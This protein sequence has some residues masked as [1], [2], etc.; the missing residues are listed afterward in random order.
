MKIKTLAITALLVAGVA[1]TGQSAKAALTYTPGDLFLGFR[2]LG[3]TGATQDYVVNI[4]QF[5]LYTSGNSF[6]IGNVG[7]DLTAVFGASWNT[8]RG[9]GNGVLWSAIGTPYNSSS[10]P[11]TVF[12]SKPQ[13]SVTEFLGKAPGASTQTITNIQDVASGYLFSSANA[14]NAAGT[15][16]NVS[17]GNSWDS[18]FHFVTNLDF[19][20]FDEIEGDFSAGVGSSGAVLDLFQIDPVNGSTATLL[21]SLSISSSGVVTF[22]AVPEPST[23][24]FIGVAAAIGAIW[25]RRRRTLRA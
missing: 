12:V 16:Q 11:K 23:M 21:G 25:L 3:G 14:S 20:R 9:E 22:T 1:L 19:N 24:A 6:T 8:D 13:S 10:D 4:G 18:K 2:A 15:I 5:S 7:T 17:D